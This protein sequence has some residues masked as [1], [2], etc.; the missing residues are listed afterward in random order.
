[1]VDVIDVEEGDV[2]PC[3]SK[4]LGELEHGVDMSLSRQGKDENSRRSFLWPLMLHLEYI[5]VETNGTL[6]IIVLVPA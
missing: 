2:E 6:V 1:M 5:L 4:K 3:E